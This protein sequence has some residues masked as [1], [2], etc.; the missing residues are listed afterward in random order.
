[1]DMYR[2]GVRVQER[3]HGNGTEFSFFLVLIDLQ[4]RNPYSSDY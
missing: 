1:M 3:L 4:K 2:N